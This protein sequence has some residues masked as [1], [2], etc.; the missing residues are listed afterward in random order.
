MKWPALRI[1]SGPELDR[2]A[3]PVGGIGTG[4]IS[5]GGR[6]D[7]RDFEVFNRPSRGF[8]P[9]AQG[10]QPSLV[11]RTRRCLP[12]EP[13][14]IRILEGA[15]SGRHLDAN[16]DAPGPW[17]PGIPRF[18][19]ASFRAAYPLAEIDLR[20]PGC[21]L[22]ARLQTFNPLVPADA[23]K[24]GLPCAVIRVVLRNPG[25]QVVEASVAATLPN[26]IGEPVSPRMPA[27]PD[28]LRRAWH[29]RE[30]ADVA[31]LFGDCTGGNPEDEA[32]GTLALVAVGA[33]SDR[34]TCRTTWA[35]GFWTHGVQDFF[36]DLLGDGRLDERPPLT[37]PGCAPAGS[38]CIETEI[39]PRETRAL[40]FLLTWHFPNRRGW[41]VDPATGTT[42]IVGNH[43]TTRF[44]DAWDA[45][46][47]IAAEIPELET[48]TLRFV[49]AFCDSDHPD[50]IKEAALSTLPV[51]RS[52]TSFRIAE[53]RFFAWEGCGSYEGSWAGTC[54]HV[55]LYDAAT[56]QLFGSIARS[57]HETALLDAAG[58]DGLLPMRVPLP[59][60]L[61]AWNAAAADGQCGQILRVL[62]EYRHHGDRR[63]LARLWPRVRGA[64]EFCWKPGGWDA[65]R[66]GVM[67]G[68]QHVTMDVDYFGPNPQTASWYLAALRAG[69]EMARI[70]EDHDFAAR[71]DDLAE[72]GR[73]FLETQLFNGEFFPQKIRP[74]P[75]D[76]KP[77][78]GIANLIPDGNDPANP[79]FQLGPAVCIDQLAAQ[80]FAHQAGLGDLFDP[81]HAE[82]ALKSILRH[83]QKRPLGNH[84][85]PLRAFA[86]PDE[87]GVLLASWPHG[88]QPTRPFPYWAEIWSGCEHL[89]AAALIWAGLEEDGLRVIADVRRRHAGHNRNPFDEAEAGSHYARSLAAWAAIPAWTR[90]RYDAPAGRF[91][92][93]RRRGRFFWATGDA[94]GI[95]RLTDRTFSLMVLGGR[96]SIAEVVVAGL[97]PESR[98]ARVVAA[99]AP[100]VRLRLPPPG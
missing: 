26:F 49:S 76:S 68:P 93:G 97:P 3:M 86:T 18:A 72:R 40:T 54:N 17:R 25:Q 79:R 90:F 80:P 16:P 14:A 5:I 57:I 2:I 7:L 37:Q 75:K 30:A 85:N 74:L 27:A 20:D 35:E 1:F 96:L 29:R 94:W 23:E 91:S 10:A 69:A 99:G 63:W 19:R 58:D 100:P 67:E 88:G 4:T 9:R 39:P 98:P 44:A 36:D 59:T 92:V 65:D 89:F 83:N 43:Y 66:D 52:Q 34:V 48:E 81:I 38:V 95:Y 28:T 84:F 78:P 47:R 62:R 73:A 77:L 22:V 13:A 8:I 61:P 24:S 11:L 15:V 12:S 33:A 60:D 45:A 31:G 56:P 46:T 51:L 87:N 41:T 70:L 42:R 50:V 55:W 71:C 64:L 82:I 6:G 53:G 21:P 32:H